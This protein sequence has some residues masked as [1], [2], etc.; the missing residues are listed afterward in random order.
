[1]TGRPCG[2]VGFI[3]KLEQKFGCRL[4]TL[5]KGRPRTKGNK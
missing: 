3:D 5:S 2:D 4:R 1:M